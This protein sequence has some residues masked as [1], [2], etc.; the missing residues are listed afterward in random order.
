MNFKNIG[1]TLSSK[2]R[3]M[4]L[5]ATVLMLALTAFMGILYVLLLLLSTILDGIMIIGAAKLLG[6]PVLVT[7]AFPLTLPSV[8]VYLSAAYI[9]GCALNCIALSFRK[10]KL[11]TA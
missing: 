9:V 6:L 10:P 3:P 8:L 7:L 5:F 4:K 2:S 1:F 11:I